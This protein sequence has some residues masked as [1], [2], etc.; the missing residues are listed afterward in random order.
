MEDSL[1]KLEAAKIVGE[2]ERV[3]IRKP[4]Q[5]KRHVR[6]DTAF[7]LLYLVIPVP[8]NPVA[9]Q[10]IGP[11]ALAGSNA[12]RCKAWV[13]A[14]RIPPLHVTSREGAHAPIA[15]PPE[16]LDDC[17]SSTIAATVGMWEIS[18]K[19]RSSASSRV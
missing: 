12:P 3:T 8:G 11:T 9:A 4:A 2:S 6:G 16:R 7:H 1:F 13:V 19:P 15:A 14:Q 5:G 10:F 17:G 18:S